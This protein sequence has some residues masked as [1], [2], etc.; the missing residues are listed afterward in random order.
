MLLY[1]SKEANLAANLQKEA[2]RILIRIWCIRKLLRSYL[3]SGLL[4]LILFSN[5]AFRFPFEEMPSSFSTMVAILLVLAFSTSF[6]AFY[7]VFYESKDLASYSPY[8][9][10]IRDY[11]C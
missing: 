1:S 4:L 3:A 6:T 7:N 10:K 11:N 2:I 8:A 9:F 5:L